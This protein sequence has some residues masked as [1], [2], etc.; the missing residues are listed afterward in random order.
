M[1]AVVGVFA[2]LSVKVFVEDVLGYR[3]LIGGDLERVQ[4]HARDLFD[5][6]GGF[7]GVF[8]GRAPRE[9]RMVGDKDA[10]VVQ[11]IHALKPF[12]DDLAGPVFVAIHVVGLEG[13]GQR[14]FPMEVVGVGSAETGYGLTGLRPAGGVMRMRVD[15]AADFGKRA[16]KHEVRR[17]IGGWLQIAFD[18]F[19]VEIERDHVRGGHGMVRDD[20]GLDDDEAA[21]AVDGAGVAPRYDDESAVNECDVGAEDGAFEFF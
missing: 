11:R 15:D 20:A 17:S 7:E 6:R 8:D 16:V 4:R 13:R 1:L 12:H 19:S 5:R 3:G 9:G 14:D 21:L 10:G 2:V 18:D